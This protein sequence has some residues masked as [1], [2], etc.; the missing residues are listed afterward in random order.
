MIL[1]TSSVKS[2]CTCQRQ[3]KRALKIKTNDFND[4]LYIQRVSIYSALAIQ[5]VK[6]DTKLAA[7]RKKGL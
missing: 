1:V 2:S 6:E 4:M 5:K 3:T 7:R